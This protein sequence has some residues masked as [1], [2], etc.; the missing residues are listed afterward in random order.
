[1][2]DAADDV[3]A[4]GVFR[5]GGRL[6]VMPWQTVAEGA[7]RRGECDAHGCAGIALTLRPD[8]TLAC[9][10]RLFEASGRYRR[11]ARSATAGE[12]GTAL[13]WAD[14]FLDRWP[15][16]DAVPLLGDG[17]DNPTPEEAAKRG[18]RLVSGIPGV[19][20]ICEDT[21][22]T[23]LDTFWKYYTAA[24][25]IIDRGARM[26]SVTALDLSVAGAGAFRALPD[27]VGDFTLSQTALPPDASSPAAQAAGFTKVG[28][29]VLTTFD[30]LDAYL[31]RHPEA[32]HGAPRM[33]PARLSDGRALWYPNPI[34]PAV[35]ADPRAWRDGEWRDEATAPPVIARFATPTRKD[36]A[37]LTIREAP[38]PVTLIGDGSWTAFLDGRRMELNHKWGEGDYTAEA[39][40]GIGIR[41]RETF[42]SP[43]RRVV[44]LIGVDNDTVPAADLTAGNPP[45][46][47][48]DDAAAGT[49]ESAPRMMVLCT[50]D[51]P[52]PVNGA[53]ARFP[54]IRKAF[55]SL[56]FTAVFT[57]TPED[58]ADANERLRKLK[59]GPLLPT[60]DPATLRYALDLSRDESDPALS[61]EE[62][63]HSRRL[64]D[65]GMARE[66][67][68]FVLGKMGHPTVHEPQWYH[69]VPIAVWPHDGT[70]STVPSAA[71]IMVKGG[72]GYAALGAALRR[73][74]DWAAGRP[75]LIPGDGFYR[76]IP[77][78]PDCPAA[79]YHVMTYRNVTENNNLGDTQLRFGWCGGHSGDLRHCDAGHPFPLPG[80]PLR[81][82]SRREAAA[83]PAGIRRIRDG[84]TPDADDAP[85]LPAAPAWTPALTCAPS[86]GPTPGIITV[87][88]HEGINATPLA[89]RWIPT[90]GVAESL[91]DTALA[92]AIVTSTSQPLL[93]RLRTRPFYDPALT[94]NP[95]LADARRL[96]AEPRFP[97]VA[98]RVGSTLIA[99]DGGQILACPAFTEETGFV[100][101]DWG[102]ATTRGEYMAVDWNK[103]QILAAIRVGSMDLFDFPAAGFEPVDGM[104]LFAWRR[105]GHEGRM[106]V[107]VYAGVVPGG[108]LGCSLTVPDRFRRRVA[109]FA[110]SQRAFA[111]ACALYRPGR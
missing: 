29:C 23:T 53:P 41:F 28:E 10:G 56:Q 96:E 74:I 87:W 91:D 89:T 65:L 7:A 71:A 77:A 73:A 66:A 111:A 93:E 8:G 50:L 12:L 110:Q 20:R 107:I 52:K 3:Q 13:A 30:R 78:A 90:V 109:D 37:T 24:M 5:D 40:E 44:T 42:E 2:N 43:I 88:R 26:A 33:I 57:P 27:P 39:C 85:D 9:M 48:R 47:G 61:D 14:G 76:V 46:A 17:A 67:L 60:P 19:A 108:T 95:R 68:A 72:D 64:V 54:A 81:D 79:D 1:M 15:D 31:T 103:R 34:G 101:A 86:C 49:T 22:Y 36:T 98:P 94:G 84:R 106:T 58:V 38:A 45:A 102:L 18:Y 104:G 11:V 92:R 25:V 51:I 21:G 99:L 75:A 97:T 35:L 69:L 62:N 80:I 55:D 70:E 100:E 16:S 32:W 63:R 4:I 83:H 82:F 6:T 59:T 105:E